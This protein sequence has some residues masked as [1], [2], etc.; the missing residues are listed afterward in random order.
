MA[1]PTDE[2]RRAAALLATSTD[3]VLEV[4]DEWIIRFAS[5][6]SD[7]LPDL[8]RAVGLSLWD[9]FP[10]TAGTAF[11]AILRA[12]RSGG[13]EVD[14]TTRDWEPGTWLHVR[15]VTVPGGQGI[16]FRD[17]SAE[18]QAQQDLAILAEEAK[19]AN[20]SKSR[21]V[22]ALAHDLH[23]PLMSVR[24][25]LALLKEQVGPEHTPIIGR[26]IA[27]LASA[28]SLVEALTEC[29]SLE[30]GKIPPKPQRV[31]L[32]P[33]LAAIEAEA[34][35]M[36]REKGLRL[37]TWLG[38]S[39]APATLETDPF[40]LARALRNLVT[41]AL[42]YTDRGGV[43]IGLRRR[44]GHYRI[45]VVDTGRG[46]EDEDL[47]QIFDSFF[48]NARPHDSHGFGLGLTTAANIV[49]LLGLTLSVRTRPARGSVFTLTLPSAP[50]ASSAGQR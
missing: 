26:L 13:S 35:P 23:Q 41:N 10:W 39:G 29:S 28:E 5:D 14:F 22:A 34:R 6:P 33:L 50:A 38:R 25:H 9:A 1:T 4:D 49:R 30:T 48:R 3:G 12:A 44:P 31:D 40:M 19:R 21:M 18:M 16:T 8:P 27:A 46:I 2:A 47:P 24:L 42:R 37:V 32:V 15:A 45:D 43:L 17:I 20:R 11:E 36:A 7:L